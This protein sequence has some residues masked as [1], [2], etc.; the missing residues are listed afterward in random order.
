[1]SEAVCT[2][3]A[4][5]NSSTPVDGHEAVAGFSFLGTLRG[6]QRLQYYA[7][8]LGG[9]PDHRAPQET[10]VSTEGVLGLVE[11]PP[12][13]G[14]G[15]Y[16]LT[17]HRHDALYRST[18]C[19][20]ALRRLYCLR[21]RDPLDA[22]LNKVGF[23]GFVLDLNNLIMPCNRSRYNIA[24]AEDEWRLYSAFVFQRDASSVVAK[25]SNDVGTT[26][27]DQ[28]R[29]LEQVQQSFFHKSNAL[30]LGHTLLTQPPL[31]SVPPETLLT[32]IDSGNDVVLPPY[33]GDFDSFFDFFFSFPLMAYHGEV[34]TEELYVGFW[35]FVYDCWYGPK[36]TTNEDRYDRYLLRTELA[37]VVESVQPGRRAFL[38]NR[39]AD[40]LEDDTHRPRA[41]KATATSPQLEAFDE[42]TT[43][44]DD[45]CQ[46]D[47]PSLEYQQKQR[48][49]QELHNRAGSEPERLCGANE[50]VISN[51]VEDHIPP[52]SNPVA[53]EARSA[54]SLFKAGGVGS[55]SLA[56]E[57]IAMRIYD[58]APYERDELDNL[59][60]FHEDISSASSESFSSDT[61]YDANDAAHVPLPRG[62]LITRMDRADW[63]DTMSLSKVKAH[64]ARERYEAMMRRR[65]LLRRSVVID[66]ATHIAASPLTVDEAEA[67]P[68]VDDG[69]DVQQEEDTQSYTASATP[70]LLESCPIGTSPSAPIRL[71]QLKPAGPVAVA[72]DELTTLAVAATE[73]VLE[74]RLHALR[75]QQRQRGPVCA[76]QQTS[77][78][79]SEEVVAEVFPL[80][81]SSVHT[82]RPQTVPKQPPRPALFSLNVSRIV[83]GSGQL[84]PVE[85]ACATGPVSA[86]TTPRASRSTPLTAMFF[87]SRPTSSVRAS[88]PSTAPSKHL[89]PHRDTKELV[90]EREHEA[91]D[92][93]ELPQDVL[94]RSPRTVPARG[95]PRCLLPRTDLTNPAVKSNGLRHSPPRSGSAQRASTDSMHPPPGPLQ[96]SFIDPRNESR[97]GALPAT[98]D[99]PAIQTFY[100]KRQQGHFFTEAA[101]TAFD[102]SPHKCPLAAVGSNVNV[103]VSAPKAISITSNGVRVRPPPRPSAA[104]VSLINLRNKAQRPSALTVPMVK[105]TPIKQPTQ[106]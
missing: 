42:A 6:K 40:T 84:H 69:G 54:Y 52:S 50:G 101:G 95:T 31:A 76:Q 15:R 55:P 73:R 51:A 58:V 65:D 67:P 14:F 106:E 62:S 85:R 45:S 74:T 71:M 77:H 19:R 20:Q 103:S 16:D 32:S 97:Y 98:A 25:A 94:F 63:D 38:V 68:V 3:V 28:F 80:P 9:I 7:D 53:T 90:P 39:V 81:P 49:K 2:P 1:M 83:T 18:A 60:D 56:N 29:S 47:F 24:C 61:G 4:A 8:I 70:A 10:T 96:P 72:R 21:E 13:H 64:R 41:A 105:G 92:V 22:H 43:S 12:L 99:E 34:V 37:P 102:P 86:P 57:S 35:G 82:P 88:R 5:T 78:R 26:I 59:I 30:R 89:S 33:T 23:V 44:D 91:P 75:A 79:E 104:L 87:M 27:T 17:V 93:V 66:T 46:S 48:Q 36:P 11:S 100:G